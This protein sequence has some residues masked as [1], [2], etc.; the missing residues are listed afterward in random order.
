MDWFEMF[1]SSLIHERILKTVLLYKE[2]ALRENHTNTNKWKDHIFYLYICYELYKAT[3]GYNTTLYL[4]WLIQFE[5][6]LG[7]KFHTG[8]NEKLWS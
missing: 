4:S 6:V 5:D 7:G 8:K 1:V 3:S 2:T